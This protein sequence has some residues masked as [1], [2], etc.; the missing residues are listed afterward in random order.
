MHGLRKRR[1][2]NW[3][4]SRLACI[5]ADLGIT[6]SAA[7]TL[8]TAFP[9]AAAIGSPVVIATTI[10]V[11][12]RKIL[13]MMLGIIILSS[14]LVYFSSSFEKMLMTRIIQGPPLLIR[15]LLRSDC[16]CRF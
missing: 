13:L 15:E 9:L 5:P 3:T 16:S 12:R 1:W 6:T 7:G 14:I 11:E 8:V 4:V 10:R 2:S